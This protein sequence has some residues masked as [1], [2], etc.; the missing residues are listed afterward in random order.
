MKK[1][2]EIKGFELVKENEPASDGELLYLFSSK[3]PEKGNPVVN[4]TRAK[5]LNIRIPGDL[6]NRV[7]IVR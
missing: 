2:W 5:H 1:N 3:F 7:Q 6:L 4:E